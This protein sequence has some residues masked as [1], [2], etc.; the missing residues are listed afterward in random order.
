MK[1]TALP[2]LSALLVA[3][4]SQQHTPT[5]AAAPH[6]EIP[7]I[8]AAP[9]ETAPGTP[10]ASSGEK[11]RQPQAV[12]ESLVKHGYKPLHRNGQL[13]YCK[14]EILTGTHFANNVCLTEAQIAHN[15]REKQQLLDNLNR[16][17]GINCSAKGCS[18]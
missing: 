9:T 7:S 12:S 5:T 14:K 15:E 2:L 3:C 17:G 11:A 18:N 13:L 6:P 8:G 1:N 4:A 16:S 10:T